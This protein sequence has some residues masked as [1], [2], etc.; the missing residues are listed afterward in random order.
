MVLT[1][2]VVGP[3]VDVVT[4]V[5]VVVVL[6]GS[7][8]VVLELTVV[9]PVGFVPVVVVPGLVLPVDTEVVRI[10]LGGTAA[11]RWAR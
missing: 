2:N 9:V 1:D 6:G 11:T 7:F 4:S 10:F 3:W 8:G 5:P